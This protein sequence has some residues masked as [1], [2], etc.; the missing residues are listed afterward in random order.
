VT[1]SCMLA[2]WLSFLVGIGAGA[3]L[4]AIVLAVVDKAMRK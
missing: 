3:I 4:L 2:S 1:A